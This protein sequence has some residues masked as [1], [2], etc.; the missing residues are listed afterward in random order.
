MSVRW[1]L[2]LFLLV[3]TLLAILL[4]A[5]PA[6]AAEPAVDP[7]Q[8]H[9]G[10]FGS[11]EE[12]SNTWSIDHYGPRDDFNEQFRDIDITAASLMRGWRTSSGFELRLGGGL[13]L[14]NGT[15][16]EPLTD[17]PPRDSDAFGLTLGGLIRYNLPELFSVRPFVDASAQFL[18]AERPFPAD[19]SAVNGFVRWGGGFAVRFDERRSLEFG[20]RLAHVSNG[21]PTSTQNPAWDG[22]GFFLGLRQ[23]V[24]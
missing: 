11:L 4:A 13:W 19:G 22:D 16:W 24:K 23:K 5:M 21:G 20:Y 3:A 1:F 17:E 14:A 10:W 12:V 18:W 7:D 9:F 2:S 15:R 8:K 6:S